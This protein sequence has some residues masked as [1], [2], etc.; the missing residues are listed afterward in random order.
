MEGEI[1]QQWVESIC[2]GGCVL[3][4]G[5]YDGM[6][7]MLVGVTVENDWSLKGSTLCFRQG[8]LQRPTLVNLYPLGISR[9]TRR[10]AHNQ[11]E[12]EGN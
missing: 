12:T 9:D 2:V 7:T 1:R 10:E 8:W 3:D 6:L 4:D 5:N 11:Q